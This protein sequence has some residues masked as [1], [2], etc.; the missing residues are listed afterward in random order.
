MKN[1]VPFGITWM[2]SYAI[3]KMRMYLLPTFA[4]ILKSYY[5]SLEYETTQKG[6]TIV[7]GILPE[8]QANTFRDDTQ[9]LMLRT[10]IELMKAD[11]AAKEQLMFTSL[12][13][14]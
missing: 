1:N 9:R 6:Y 13:Q 12:D 3:I 4:E 2:N 14:L 5:P 7:S 11:L 10:K 8:Q